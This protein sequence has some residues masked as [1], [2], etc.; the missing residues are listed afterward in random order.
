M[1]CCWIAAGLALAA[2]VSA[3]AAVA[4]PPEARDAKWPCQQIK[5]A[6][7]SLA[8]VWNGPLPDT[9]QGDW[10]QDHEVAELVAAIVPRRVP[11][12]Q[13]QQKI[14]AFAVRIGATKQPK[15]LAT[16]SGVFNVLDAERT[17][18]IVGL[19]RFG[20]RQKEL[21][22]ALRAANERLRALQSDPRSD[23]GELNQM[24]QRV[25]WE[26]QV[27]QDRREAMRYAC[28]VPGKIEQRLFALAQA[29]RDAME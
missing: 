25:S 6:Q 14:Q 20:A 15:L 26:A 3:T 10:Q 27:F 13:A 22:T 24:M 17:S 11:L 29:I 2:A 5:V 4:A 21:A 9:Q 16:L 8:A 23:P 18:V 1:R 12:E 19:D 28:D 7:L